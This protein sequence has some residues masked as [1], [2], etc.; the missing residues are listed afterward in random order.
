VRRVKAR[1]RSLSR[2]A[3]KPRWRVWY[4]TKEPLLQFSGKFCVLLAGFHFLLLIP[5]CQRMV[6]SSTVGYA[7]LSSLILNWFG[8][9]AHFTGGTIWTG[10]FGITVLPACTAI[11]LPLFFAALVIAFPSSA[12]RKILGILVGGALLLGLNLLRVMNLYFLGVHLP[13]L[14]DIAHEQLWG[15][16][17]TSVTVVL[18]VVW[19]TWAAKVARNEVR[20]I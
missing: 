19:I 2:A 17:F 11:E 13:K 7:R 8:E 1:K 10:H 18:S 20:A 9:G 15:T 4:A 16:I 14:F 5:I 12:V 3:S 6:D